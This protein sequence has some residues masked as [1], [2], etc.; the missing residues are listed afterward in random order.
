MLKHEDVRVGN[1]VCFVGRSD[2]FPHACGVVCFVHKNGRLDVTYDCLS[3]VREEQCRLEDW[4][5]TQSSPT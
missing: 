3:N 2:Q 5:L 1:N 4:V